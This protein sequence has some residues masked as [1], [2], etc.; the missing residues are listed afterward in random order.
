MTRR[1]FQKRIDRLNAAVS[2]ARYAIEHGNIARAQMIFTEQI[3]PGYVLIWKHYMRP[4]AL[5]R[6]WIDA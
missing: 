2:T 4:L 6:G 3:G 5:R 1:E